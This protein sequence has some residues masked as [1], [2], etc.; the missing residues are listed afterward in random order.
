VRR[1]RVVLQAR[2]GDETG[3][4]IAV[5]RE[6]H[7]VAAAGRP[8]ALPKRRAKKMVRA[9]RVVHRAAATAA[10]PTLRLSRVKTGYEKLRMELCARARLG[11]FLA[12]FVCASCSLPA[13]ATAAPYTVQAEIPGFGDSF[14]LGDQSV[15]LS[16]DGNTALIGAWYGNGGDAAYVFTRSRSTWTLQAKLPFD[17]SAKS[18]GDSVALSADGNTAIVGAGFRGED[19]GAF[20]YTRSG[21][22]W[23]EQAALEGAGSG[24]KPGSGFG[25]TVALSSDGNTAL[26]G[27]R[28]QGPGN[29]EGAAWVFSRV[30]GVW[31]RSGAP[32]LRGAG[33]ISSPVGSTTQAEFGGSLTLSRDGRVALIGAWRDN[34]SRGAAWV[35]ERSG[36]SWI[37]RA[38]LTALDEIGEGQ[39]GKAL[40]L[41]ADGSLALIG[42]NGAAWVFARSGDSW[43]QQ[44]PRIKTADDP[45]EEERQFAGSVALSSDGSTA[46]FGAQG[47]GEHAT[48]AAW[49][50]RRSRSSFAQV[51]EFLGSTRTHEV[52]FGS[53]VALSASGTTAL[54]SA[55]GEFT[56][57]PA[58]GGAAW[59]FV[60]PPWIS[61]GGGR[62]NTGSA[63]PVLSH[64]SQS[65][66]RWREH[67]SRRGR[68]GRVP[69]GTTF[70][71]ALNE[72]ADVS[73]VFA[74]YIN[75]SHSERGCVARRRT[76]HRRR[77]CE[78]LL[79]RGSLS[80]VAR[81]G[82]NRIDFAGRLAHS[83]IP[84]GSYDV[85]I[86][87]TNGAG[88]RSSAA[89]L[90]FTIVE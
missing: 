39:F 27:G 86:T 70:S 30:G 77:P 55:P 80:V 4:E 16:D 50:F 17:Y 89:R 68:A 34:T 29:Q 3:E 72:A 59:V 8:S 38:K 22:T 74:Q 71:F 21:T 62:L 53:S 54:V 20:V 35:F 26:V 78:L 81:A 10:R 48:G 83:S 12:V 5:A 43:E 66:R 40:A 67:T 57:P 19:T 56:R 6:D 41:S 1:I 63:R 11:A 90:T 37:E 88:R 18:F 79:N 15:A 36:A 60:G 51:Q 58:G 13:I 87:A 31:T 61:L 2:A 24:A 7:G 46:L 28:F 49:I 75:G 52:N 23:S 45:T 82:R 85:A 64:V 73:L 84:P 32:M 14:G 76:S 69:H 42:G 65:H 47:F 9:E 25:E 33:E 44:G